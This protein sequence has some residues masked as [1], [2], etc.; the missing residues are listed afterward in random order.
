MSDLTLFKKD[1]L[2]AYLKNIQ[3]DETTKS[4]MGGAQSIPRI[5]IKG[6]VFRKIVNGEEVMKNEDR[7]MN[8]IIVK[9]APTEYR[10][11]YA[12]TYKE[13]ESKGPDCWSSDGESPDP[14]IKSPQSA[15]CANCPQ[16][17]KGSGQGDSRACRFSRWMAVMLENDP[18]GDVMQ[19]VLPAQ[20]VFGK[21]EKG[22]LPLR[23]Y[24]TFMAGHNLPITAVVTEMRFDT[25][26]ST[27]KL[28]F[29]PVRPLDE[30]EYLKAQS[31]ADSPEVTQALTMRF[32]PKNDVT[33]EADDE[34]IAVA[35]AAAAKLKGKVAAPVVD[36]GDEEPEPKVRGKTKEADVKSVLDQWADDDE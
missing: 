30:E 2:P 34:S 15:K 17:I 9:A 29:K 11:F 19:L 5:S 31:R 1:K 32:S 6:S 7:A 18:D 14:S 25:N 22:K 10:T 16:N 24:S 8:I 12:G 27:P 20:S 13:G 35:Q 36:G 21:G 4:L 23:A 33:A 3:L 28:T 26:S